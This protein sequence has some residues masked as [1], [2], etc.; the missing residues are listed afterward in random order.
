MD[1]NKAD[2]VNHPP[3]YTHYSG[4]EVIEITEW[5][6][7]NIGNAVKYIS[8]AG[9]KNPDREIEDLEKAL[10][11]LDREFMRSLDVEHRLSDIV[12]RMF[13]HKKLDAL[14]DQ[15]VFKR[16]IAVYNM[17]IAYTDNLDPYEGYNAS[18]DALEHEIERMKKEK[19]R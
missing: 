18:R 1:E 7:F 5:L 3:H 10:W 17:V 19:N 9:L 12:D 2:I 14:C 16:G 15:M 11:Y 8:R 13:F 6:S 4:V